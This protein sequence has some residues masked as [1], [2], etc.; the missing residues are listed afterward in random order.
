MAE[1]FS[2]A[3]A[4]RTSFAEAYEKFRRDTDLAAFDFD[5]E[6]LFADVRDKSSELLLLDSK[7]GNF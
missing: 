6:V 2:I 3:D 1:T 7:S 5:P 4:R